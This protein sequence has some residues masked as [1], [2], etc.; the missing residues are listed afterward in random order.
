ML[1]CLML[2][3]PALAANYTINI[4]S[5]NYTQVLENISTVSDLS[6]VNSTLA[7]LQN[8]TA[9][10]QANVTALQML[11]ANITYLTSF[12]YNNSIIAQ[13]ASDRISVVLTR[14]DTVESIYDS[15][16]RKYSSLPANLQDLQDEIEG[17]TGGLRERFESIDGKISALNNSI[18]YYVNKVYDDFNNATT[19]LYNQQSGSTLMLEMIVAV[20]LIASNAVTYILIKKYKMPAAEKGLKSGLSSSR[21]HI[22]DDSE[23]TEV[24]RRKQLRELKKERLALKKVPM[25]VRAVLLHKVDR[26]EV[27]T[28]EEAK[29]EA[30]I[31]TAQKG[32]YDSKIGGEKK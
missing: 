29:E 17:R 10:I 16:N 23:L 12:A 25:P 9:L 4:S 11:P 27:A 30:A 32:A 8:T 1:L 20:A 13:N 18:V 7:Q 14:V 5:I 3:A 28:L 21:G 19:Q 2:A 24:E 15:L 22:Y 31:L 6:A 26:S